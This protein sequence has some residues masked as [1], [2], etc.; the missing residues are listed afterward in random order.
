MEDTAAKEKELTKLKKYDLVQLI[1]LLVRERDDLQRSCA[2]LE[3]EYDQ[4]LEYKNELR[5][6]LSDLE[7]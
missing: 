7:P 1:L 3:I 2:H 6:R 4:L 5:A